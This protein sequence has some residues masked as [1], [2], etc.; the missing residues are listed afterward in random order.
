ML[1]DKNKT[2]T[3]QTTLNRLFFLKIKRLRSQNKYKYKIGKQGHAVQ[4]REL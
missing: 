1:Y 4:Y 2:S 3:V